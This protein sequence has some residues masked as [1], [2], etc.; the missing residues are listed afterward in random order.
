[1]S[2]ANV[3]RGA[4][5]VAGPD[6]LA[7]RRLQAEHEIDGVASTIG[8][9]VSRA[10][11]SPV[12]QPVDTRR[13]RRRRRCSWRRACPAR[14]RRRGST[15]ATSRRGAGVVPEPARSRARRP[16]GVRPASRAMSASVWF[17]GSAW[18]PGNHGTMPESSCHSAMAS[19]VARSCAAVTRSPMSPGMAGSGTDGLQRAGGRTGRSVDLVAAALDVGLGSSRAVA[20]AWPMAGLRA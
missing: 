18:P 5:G 20:A 4:I 11:R 9:I 6:D 17:Q 12:E 7:A 10:P 2:S 3:P 19:T 14:R 13:R 16:R 15:G 1:M 8:H